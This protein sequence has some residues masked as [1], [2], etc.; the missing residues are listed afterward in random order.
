MCAVTASRPRTFIA[1]VREHGILMP[2]VAYRDGHKIVVR[3]RHRRTLAALEVGCVV[4]TVVTDTPDDVSRI[5]SQL[6]ENDH[7]AGLGTRDRVTAFEQLALLGHS[8]LRSPSGPVPS[9]PRS[10]LS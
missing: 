2:V 4:P 5:L 1:S 9:G 10:T 3:Y 8:P 7:R 6:G